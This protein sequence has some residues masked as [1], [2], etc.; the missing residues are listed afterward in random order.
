MCPS[1]FTI[2]FEEVVKPVFRNMEVLSRK[3]RNLRAQRDLLL[4]KLISGEIDVSEVGEQMA[5]A[6]AD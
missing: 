4:P 5:E 3:N 6:A 1:D 2:G